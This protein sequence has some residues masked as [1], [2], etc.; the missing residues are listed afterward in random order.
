ML[1]YIVDFEDAV[2]Y[3]LSPEELESRLLHLV[4]KK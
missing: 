2:E 4:K 3:A 1:P